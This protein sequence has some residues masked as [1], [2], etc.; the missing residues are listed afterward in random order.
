MI[1][2]ITATYNSEKTIKK[3]IESVNSQVNI[4]IEHIF[5]D[6]ESSDETLNI[7]KKYSR[8]KKRIYSLKP[9]GIYQAMNFGIK[10]ARG[11]IIGILNSDDYYYNSNI[12][13]IVNTNLKSQKIDIC[14]GN[15]KFFHP[16]SK[17]ITRVWKSSNFEHG[18]F[19]LGW[20]PPHPTFF[21]KKK[22]YDK[23]GLF[24]S[25][26]GNSADIEFMFRLLEINNVR[27]KFVNSYFVKMQSGGASNKNLKTI[28][29]QNL[30]ILKIFSD[31]NYNFSKF[32]YFYLKF[33][34]RLKQIFYNY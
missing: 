34:S 15:L 13:N 28:V 33:F 14:Y 12:L 29:Y 20:S 6:G 10:K 31:Y 26:Y 32:N 19:L 7:I 27:S 3:T 1:S 18:S 23:F 21:V 8:V 4:N 25:K 17:K 5:V 11:K 24:K 9:S 22:I 16:K 30:K 2:I